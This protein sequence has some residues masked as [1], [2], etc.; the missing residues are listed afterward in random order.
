VSHVIGT[1]T[2]TKSLDD[3][4]RV[5]VHVDYDGLTS[6]EVIGLLTVELDTQRADM[7]EARRP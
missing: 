3:E 4:G 6:Y 1:I 7:Q 5:I 2:I